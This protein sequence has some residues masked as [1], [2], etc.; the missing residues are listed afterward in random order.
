VTPPFDSLPQPDDPVVA[1]WA[2][3]LND[4]GYWATLLDAAWRYAFVTDDLRSSWGDKAEARAVPIGLHWF[5][6]AA[7]RH[8]AA[9]FPGA[10]T[11]TGAGRRAHF[12]ALGG[13]VLASTSGGRDELRRVVDPELADLVDEL[14]PQAFSAALLR[15]AYVVA[16]TDVAATRLLL[17]IDDGYGRMAGVCMLLKPAIGMAQL[18]AAAAT[19]DLSHLERMS[20]VDRPDRRPAAI[21]MADLEASSPLARR[22]SSTQYFTFGRRLMRAEDQ[23]IVDA[24]GIVGRHAG[25]GCVAYFLGGAAGGESAAARTCIATARNLRR[26]LTD[27]AERSD[28]P[29]AEL[30]LRFGLHWGATLYIGRVH[31]AGRSEVTALGDEMN[32]AARIEACATGGRALASKSL[33]ERLNRSDAEAVGIDIAHAKYT[34]LADLSTATDKARRDAPAIAVCEI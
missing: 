21:L 30:S 2:F 31:T 25:D 4:A 11:A 17:R 20:A 13:Y 22:L 18:V 28:V 29:A 12:V 7:T 14:Q 23:C 19:A 6:A 9:V 24:G 33:I 1:A 27:V 32:E 8:R 26:I 15:G 5:S 10:T 34:P 3:A 16:G